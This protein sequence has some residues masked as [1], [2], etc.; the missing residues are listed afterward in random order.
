MTHRINYK[1]LEQDEGRRM[2]CIC[3]PPPFMQEAASLLRE[4]FGF[5]DDE[6][7]NFQG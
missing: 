1:I 7:H 6:I 5:T 4:E 2:A 3:G